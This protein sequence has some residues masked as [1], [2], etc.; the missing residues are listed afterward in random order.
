M[1][2]RSERNREHT[3]QIYL[4][5]SCCMLF[6]VLREYYT[7]SSSLPKHP[8]PVNYEGSSMAV[9]VDGESVPLVTAACFHA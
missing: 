2:V 6:I 8:L 4:L 3:S 7:E 1:R 5:R 9:S